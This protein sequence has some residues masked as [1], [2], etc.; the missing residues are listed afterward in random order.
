MLAALLFQ[1]VPGAPCQK[2]EGAVQGV[3]MGRAAQERNVMCCQRRQDVY[4]Q[5]VVANKLLQQFDA[6]LYLVQGQVLVGLVCLVDG[7]GSHNDGFHAQ[8]L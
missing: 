4:L 8:L 2:G 7:A 6:G 1:G 3:S 5:A